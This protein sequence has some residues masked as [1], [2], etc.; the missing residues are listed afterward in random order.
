MAMLKSVIAMWG[1]I[2][3][4]V[5]LNIMGYESIDRMLHSAYVYFSMALLYTKDI[6][7]I[8]MSSIYYYVLCIYYRFH[9]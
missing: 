3:N 7:R 5:D 8:L 4:L 6:I 2:G 9:I 1:C